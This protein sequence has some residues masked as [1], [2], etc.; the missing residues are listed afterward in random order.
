MTTP[1]LNKLRMYMAVMATCEKFKTNWQT[2]TGFADGYAE[3]I[4]HVNALKGFRQAELQPST[5][6]AEE[7][8]RRREVMSKAGAK[9]AGA[10]HAYAVK[11]GDGD[12][13]ARSDFSYSDLL[14]GRDSDSSDRCQNLVTI[15]TPMVAALA[16]Y[17]VTAAQLTDA[18]QKIT[19]YMEIKDKPAQKVDDRAGNNQKVAKHFKGADELLD[20]PLDDTIGQ[21]EDSDADFF[22]AYKN[23]RKIDD[24]ASTRGP[25]DAPPAPTPPPAG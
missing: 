8:Q 5:G 12:L 21:F 15:A 19:A 1:Q 2:V 4:V 14:E 22:I 23:A 11:Q 20:S 17:K 16:N 18:Q 7:K 24:T 6:W 10:I 25:G 9:I 13:A 3:W